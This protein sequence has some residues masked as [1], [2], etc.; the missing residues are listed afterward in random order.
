MKK[1][2]FIAA[3]ASA[4]LV[5]CTKNEVAQVA[6]QSVI[7]FAAPVVAPATKASNEV[8]NNYPTSADYAF[9]VWAKYHS[10]KVYNVGDWATDPTYM[11]NVT[12]YYGSNSWAPT[13]DYY[14]PKN[15]TLSFIAYSPASV[16]ASCNSNGIQ[17]ADY[18]VNTDLTNQRDILFSERA[19]EKQT[20]NMDTNAGANGTGDNEG[21]TDDLYT[22]I[23]LAFKH[24]LSSI[25]FTVKTEADYSAS[26]KIILKSIQIVNADTK[27]S[28][29]QGLTDAKASATPA[30]DCWTMAGTTGTYKVDN[31]EA[32]NV[33]LTNV[34]YWTSTQTTTSPAVSNGVRPTDFMLIPQNLS[35]V[36]L[37]VTYTIQNGTG[38]VLDQ[39]YEAP[40]STSTVAMWNRGKR[41]IYNIIIGLDRIY[42]EPYVADWEDV[43]VEDVEI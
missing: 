23:H 14:W 20:S 41:Y 5:S 1:L 4:A 2:F 10:D 13:A 3:I 21:V 43:T 15:G 39:V 7:T 31:T 26:T 25:A 8:W 33:V 11:D 19:V 35:G 24:A 37:K 42:F 34:A 40:I 36:T 30:I 22:G 16:D 18:V 27:G 29:N 38:P 6:D 17:I 9:A 12:V 28:F 32:L